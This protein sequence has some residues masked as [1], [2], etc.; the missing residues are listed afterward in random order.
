MNDFYKRKVVT[1]TS[2]LIN[3]LENIHLPI[4]ALAYSFPLF[5]M[6]GDCLPCL[7]LD[8]KN[9]LTLLDQQHEL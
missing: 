6:Q 1:Q 5:K 8:E 2:L 4:H 7:F 3:F 9:R